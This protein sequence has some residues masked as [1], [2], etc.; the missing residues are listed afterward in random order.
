M[1]LPPESVSPFCQPVHGYEIHHGRTGRSG[2]GEGDNGSAA[3]PLLNFADGASCG[4]ADRSGRIWGSYLHGIF[5]S[6][7]FRRWFINQLRTA[8]GLP[9]LVGQGAK[10]DLEPAL[11][12]LAAVLRR[13]MDMGAVYR[14]L[15]I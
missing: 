8:K 7:P 11:D 6:D 13:E 4:A 3:K 12:R 15:G 10:Y 2:N 9:A 1:G 14:L 5:D